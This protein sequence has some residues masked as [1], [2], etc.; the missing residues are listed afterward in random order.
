MSAVDDAH[1]RPLEDPEHAEAARVGAGTAEAQDAG[2]RADGKPE[3]GARVVAG[4]GTLGDARQLHVVSDAPRRGAEERAE[5]GEHALPGE[6][7]CRGTAASSWSATGASIR[8]S[9]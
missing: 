6:G 7:G 1:E 8:V 9:G 5:A 4:E 3:Q 2:A